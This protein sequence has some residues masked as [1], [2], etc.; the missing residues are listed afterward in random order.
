MKGIGK[1]LLYVFAVLALI[2]FVWVLFSPN[3]AGSE[4]DAAAWMDNPL[5]TF[6]IVISLVAV[7]LATVV[8]LVYKVIDW[9]KYPSHMKEALWVLGA[10]LIAA[11]VGF[12]FSGSDQIINA[13]GLDYSGMKSKM[14]GTGIIMT[15]VLLLLGLVFLLWDTVKGII[16]G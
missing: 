14:I 8:F 13:E 3:S 11:V 15:G 16:K 1:I 6:V 7:V 9:F 10:I 5:T 2:S 12:V 4:V